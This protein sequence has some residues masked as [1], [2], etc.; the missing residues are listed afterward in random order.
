[1][2]HSVPTETHTHAY[3]KIALFF[4]FWGPAL[5]AALIAA[6]AWASLD[7]DDIASHLGTHYVIGSL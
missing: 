4:K 7:K 5:L 2:L 3:K 6:N 1:M